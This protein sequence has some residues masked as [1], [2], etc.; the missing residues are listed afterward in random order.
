MFLFYFES[1]QAKK[2][3]VTYEI[4]KFISLSHNL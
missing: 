3:G 4:A 2:L 1:R